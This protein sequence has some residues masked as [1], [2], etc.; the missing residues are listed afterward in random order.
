MNAKLWGKV[1]VFV[2][3]KFNGRQIE[4]LS[5]REPNNIVDFDLTWRIGNMDV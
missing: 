2:Y 1:D 3:S 5:H 4:F